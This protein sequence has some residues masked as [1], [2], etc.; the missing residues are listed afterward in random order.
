MLLIILGEKARYV[1]ASKNT[2]E[3]ATV[4]IIDCGRGKLD[5]FKK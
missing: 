2:K 3:N 4:D 5:R 1:E